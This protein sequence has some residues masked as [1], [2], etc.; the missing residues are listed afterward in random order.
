MQAADGAMQVA[1]PGF[2]ARRLLAGRATI[3]LPGE[4][5]AGEQGRHRCFF[6]FCENDFSFSS[7]VQT[8]AAI[9]IAAGT[10]V[11]NKQAATVEGHR[12]NALRACVDLRDAW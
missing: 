12:R 5:H 7:S 4:G 8:Q 9:P 11:D 1:V 6:S 10:L 3:G 2:C